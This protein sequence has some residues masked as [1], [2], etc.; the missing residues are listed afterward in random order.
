MTKV[1]PKRH[2]FPNK[3]LFRYCSANLS[4]RC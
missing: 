4:T 2:F 1:K 3:V